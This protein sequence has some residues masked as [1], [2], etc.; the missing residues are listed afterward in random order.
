MKPVPGFTQD[1][2]GEKYEL[3]VAY[4]KEYVGNIHVKPQFT[5]FVFYRSSD[6]PNHTEEE[7]RNAQRIYM[8]TDK[9][10]FT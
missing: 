2:Y 6:V 8:V 1:F 3:L 4:T 9:L 7:Y 5:F 10:P